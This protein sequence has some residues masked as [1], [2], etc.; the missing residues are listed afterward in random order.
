MAKKYYVVW[1][2]RE[3]GIFSDWI[4]CKKQIDKFAGARYKSFTTLAEAEAAFHGGSVK[5]ASGSPVKK[6]S[7]NQTVKT[8]DAAEIAAMKIDTKIFT[9]GGCEPNPG[10]AGSGVAIYRNN[11]VDELWYGLFN[12]MGTNNTA[13]LNALHQA[14]IMAGDEIGSNRSVVIFC[15]SKYAIQCITQWAVNW[16]KKGWKKAG[17]EIRNLELIKQMFTLYQSLK[18][19]L[20][21]LHVNGHVGVEG[22]ELA[23][24][25]S[26]LAIES[27][28]RDFTRYSDKLDIDALLAM[29][30]G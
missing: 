18:E 14:L 9:D 5:S 19:K 15:D 10:K 20:K 13:E 28:N 25:M 4:S 7:S 30:A 12:P 8:Y 11:Q 2:G 27:R 29:R 21:I 1:Q 22:N 17:G 24:R 6:R 16:Q 3:P 23:D 26:I